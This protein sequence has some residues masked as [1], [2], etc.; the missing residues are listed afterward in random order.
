MGAV[1][2]VDTGGARC[3]GDPNMSS[4]GGGGCR[5][6]GCGVVFP[7]GVRLSTVPAV[8][9]ADGLVGALVAVAA[10]R[11]VVVVLLLL[12]LLFSCAAA[13]DIAAGG[14]S[15]DGVGVVCRRAKG[16]GVAGE[17]GLRKGE[18]RVVLGGP[19]P[20]REGVLRWP[21]GSACV[22]YKRRL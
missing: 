8:E 20:P 12:L 17:T 15:G 22:V 13:G 19:P 9:D 11:E 10:K 18:F 14:F 16:A 3:R 4:P 2:A 5:G 6:S 1:D 21:A 7:R